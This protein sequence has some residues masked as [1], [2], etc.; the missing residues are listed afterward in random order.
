MI[1]LDYCATTPMSADVLKS[2]QVVNTEYWGNPSSLHEFGGIANRLLDKAKE[3]VLSVV[4]GSD[5]QVIFTSGATESNNIALQG[6]AHQYKSRGN[7]IITTKVEHNSVYKTCQQLEEEGFRVTY[8]NVNSY[9]MIE[10]EELIKAITKDTIL[11]SI[12]HVNGEIGTINPIYE[13]GQYIKSINKRILFHV[14]MVQSFGKVDVNLDQMNVDLASVSAH[15]IFGPK[16][17]GALIYRNKIELHPI[18]YGGGQQYKIRSGTIDVAGAV[19]LSKA[20]RLIHET[21]MSHYEHVSHLNQMIY[22]HLY[23]CPELTV[24]SHRDYSSPYIINF[25]LKNIKAE[26]FVHAFSKHDIYLSSKSACSSKT[27]SPSRILKA[28]GLDDTLASQSIRVSLSY[29][30][31]EAEIQTF[32]QVLDTVIKEVMVKK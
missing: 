4:N 23:Q 21:L 32:I 29:L 18:S 12:M 9:G 17:V 13:I 16:G 6:I 7:H 2:Y 20:M 3:Q 25:S 8:L 10:W 26:T 1:Y 31:T 30:T 24:N 11:V 19:C 14:D 28:I 27:N 22:D 5:H 15:K